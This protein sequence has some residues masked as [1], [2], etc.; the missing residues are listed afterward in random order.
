MRLLRLLATGKSLEGFKDSEVRYQVT[1]QRLLPTF[2]SA[3]NPFR[4]MDRPGPAP[5]DARME[6]K[7][8]TVSIRQK[9][10]GVE[11]QAPAHDTAETRASAASGP[12]LALVRFALRKLT[13]ALQPRAAAFQ[14]KWSEKFS[15]LL[16]RPGGK[17]A[18]VAMPHPTKLPVQEELSLDKIKVVRNDLSDADLEVVPAKSPAALTSVAPAWPSVN[19]TGAGT[20]WGR[21]AGRVFRAG[22]V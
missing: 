13:T 8:T 17:A 3:K 7:G 6:G 5:L 22:K 14:S 16:S 2:G 19:K 21:L 11:A 20:A 10:T 12:P 9:A 18:S 15:A 4:A 1:G